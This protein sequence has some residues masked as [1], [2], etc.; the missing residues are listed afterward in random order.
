MW[1]V[2]LGAAYLLWLYQRVFL[3]PVTNPKNEHL[4][5]LTPR[6]IATFVPL[7]ILAVWIGVYPKPFF[8]I[9]EQPV[10]QIVQV[11]RT[12]YK[13]MNANAMP[14]QPAS[15]E[16]APAAPAAAAAEGHR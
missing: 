12:D 6:E 16:T 11:V 14:A 15:S 5:D 10:Q 9:L 2:V 3:G 1:G 4:A 8:R 7:L 13:T